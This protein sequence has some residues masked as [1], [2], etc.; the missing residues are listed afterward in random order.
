LKSECREEAS[1]PGAVTGYSQIGS[2]DCKFAAALAFSLN[3]LDPHVVAAAR[4]NCEE[5]VYLRFMHSPERKSSPFRE[6]FFT[7]SLM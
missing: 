7:F 5:Y 1:I 6:L 4:D 2:R 3:P